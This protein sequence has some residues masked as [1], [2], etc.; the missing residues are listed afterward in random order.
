MNIRRVITGGLFVFF[1]YVTPLDISRLIKEGSLS[2]F[3]D[4]GEYSFLILVFD[5]AL[6]FSTYHD[7]WGGKKK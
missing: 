1:L 2:F 4:F 6:L 5:F 7:T 3:V